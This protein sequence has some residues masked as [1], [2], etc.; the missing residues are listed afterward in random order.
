M[1]DVT[2][3]DHDGINSLKVKFMNLS[4]ALIGQKTYNPASLS[5]GTGVTT[6]VTV[7]GATLGNLAFAS[8][9]KDLQGV[10]MTAYV[11]APDTISVRFQNGTAGSV[12]ISEGVLTAIT[13]RI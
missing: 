12:D 9:S 3:H 1:N 11:S 13:V 8:F 6:T 4:G 10:S 2:I 5:S 7:R